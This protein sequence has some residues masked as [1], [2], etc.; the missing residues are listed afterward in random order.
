MTSVIL[1]ILAAWGVRISLSVSRHTPARLSP[2]GLSFEWSN[3]SALAFVAGLGFAAATVFIEIEA[4]YPIGSAAVLVGL[5]SLLVVLSRRAQTWLRLDGIHQQTL[6]GTTRELRWDAIESVRC[7]SW[8]YTIRIQGAGQTLWLPMSYRGLTDLV[9][10][11]L[12][13]APSGVI[14]KK[15]A[16]A[17]NKLFG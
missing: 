16:R 3:R 12:E 17:L 4:V 1:G 9:A 10:L 14:S 11:L 6:L 2:D 5:L 13:R 15:T 7:F 8:L